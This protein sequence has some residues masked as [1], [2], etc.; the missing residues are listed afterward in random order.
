MHLGGSRGARASRYGNISK[1]LLGTYPFL[2]ELVTLQ[3]PVPTSDV[4]LKTVYIIF[5]GNLETEASCGGVTNGSDTE[6]YQF[7]LDALQLDES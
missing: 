7:L 6:I 5:V 4:L 2:E 3:H 1:Y